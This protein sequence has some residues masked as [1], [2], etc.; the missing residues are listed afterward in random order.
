VAFVN[1]MLGKPRSVGFIFKIVMMFAEPYTERM[2]GLTCVYFVVCETLKL[3]NSIFLT[4]VGL[5]G[6]LW[7]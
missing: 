6:I 1:D 3:V 5:L 2:A 7:F 4:F